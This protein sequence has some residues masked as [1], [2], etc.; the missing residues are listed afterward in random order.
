MG[1]AK[2]LTSRTDL[3]VGDDSAGRGSVVVVPK[4]V[5]AKRDSLALLSLGGDVIHNFVDGLVIGVAFV[6]SASTGWAVTIAV[7]LHELPL[8]MGDFVLLL[9]AGW[10]KTKAL[11]A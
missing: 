2:K 9:H 4:G 10:T 11:A 7:I 8:E 6:E 3:E 1:K 5:Q